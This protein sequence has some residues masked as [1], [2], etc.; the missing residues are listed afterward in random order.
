MTPGSTAQGVTLTYD[1]EIADG[2]GASSYRIRRTARREDGVS[3]YHIEK[4]DKAGAVLQ[5]WELDT[6]RPEPGTFNLMFGGRSVEAGMLPLED[7]VQVDIR[8]LSTDISVVDP[9]RKALRTAA[10]S[11]GGSVK[12][13]MPGRV[14]RLLVQEGDSV[15][16]GT[17][18]MVIEAMKMEN[19]IKSPRDGVV[20]RFAV[21]AGDLVEARAVLV[22]LA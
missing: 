18:L 12:S 21:A 22:D 1:V 4:I 9:R 17:P 14:V 8:G 20:S 13:Q 2:P 15:T 7:G 11:G 3:H 6:I 10:G 5:V 19:E 16:K